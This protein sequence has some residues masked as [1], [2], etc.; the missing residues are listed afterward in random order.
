MAAITP[1]VDRDVLSLATNLERVVSV[2]RRLMPSEGLSL[3]A[4]STLRHLEL[5]GSTRLTELAAAQAV[6]QPA[7]TQLVTR[8][9]RDELVARHASG[10]DARV[11]LVD[12]TSAGRELLARQRAVRAERLSELLDRVPVRDRAT[13][14]AATRAMELLADLGQDL[15]S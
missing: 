7:M 8:L 14:L 10:S 13:I 12:L 1:A 2:I 15:I 4:V 5:S 6:S 11:V 9:E 3:T